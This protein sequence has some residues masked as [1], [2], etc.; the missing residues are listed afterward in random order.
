MVNAE[1]IRTGL[2]D[3]SKVI[4]YPALYGAR[5]A[6]AFSAT[7]RSITVRADQMVIIDDKESSTGSLFTDGVG[8]ISPVVLDDIWS[9]S[10]LKRGRRHGLKPSAL[11]IRMGGSKGMLCVDSGLQGKVVC[12]RP[13]M[14]KFI[15]EDRTIELA[16]VFDRPMSMYLNRPL[17]MLLETLGIPLEP[18]M[19][20]QRDAVDGTKAATTSMDSTAVLLE[21]YGLGNSYHMPSLFL[22]LHRINAHS[23]S[24]RQVGGLLKL[25]QRV[26][27]FAA[28]HV[29][30]D[31]KYKARIFVP[32][33][34]T[35]V[36]I[37]DEYDYLEEGEIYGEDSLKV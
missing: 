35:L 34:W 8:T 32:K 36:G 31:I 24:N 25:L 37:A 27:T 3:F 5:I 18:F 29:L 28:N 22:D 13:S 4:H 15:S 30:R 23:G 26:Q 19:E 16:R 20:L 9:V 12:T 2:G 17:I 11:Q 33:A 1:S 7:E 21:K 6:Q 14:N 10:G